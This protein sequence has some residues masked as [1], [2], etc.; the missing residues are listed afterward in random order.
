MRVLREAFDYEFSKLDPMAAHIDPPSVAVYETLL[1][2]GP[3]LKPYPYLGR[4]T[5]VS[6][7]GLEWI[8]ELRRGAVFH[9]GAP[10]DAQAVVASLEALRWHVSGAR[11]LWYWD[12]VD[13]VVAID[14]RHIKFRLHYP[15]S[16]L[17]ALLWGTHTAVFNVAL[18]QAD[19]DTFGIGIADGTGPYRMLS[20]SPERIVA[21]TVAGY[22]ARMMPE[23]RSST[24][25]IDRIEWV[26]IPDPRI[27]LE[28][29]R[30]GGIDCLHGVDYRDVVLLSDDLDLQVY[31]AGQASSMYWSLNW[32]RSD[33]GF[34][35]VHVRRAISLGIDRRALVEEVL[36]GHGVPTW[37][38]LPPGTQYYDASVD[39]EGVA[40]YDLACA[41]LDALGWHRGLDG[42][43]NRNGTRMAFDCVIQRD[44]VFVGVAEVLEAQLLRLG[45]E[46]RIIPVTPFAEFYG[47]CAAGPDSTISK[48]LWPD[49]VD[50]LIGFSSTST[51]PFPNW[52]R[53]SVPELDALFEAWLHADSEEELTSA[54][55]AVQHTFA[56][57]LPYLPLLAPADV[58]VWGSHVKGFDP[59][60]GI[61]YPFYQGVDVDPDP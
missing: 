44:A 11:Q 61:L 42:I 9:S 33:L 27:R 7:S 14:D 37:G 26:S 18:Q 46:I 1:A 22:P 43:R 16:R 21:E 56:R 48:W 60:P 52:S 40:N 24:R 2:K 13:T 58:W 54:A 34:D 20:F 28:V 15:Y 4:V 12:P 8:L 53:A 29:L 59:S 39:L 5:E 3:D 55:S 36:H 19:P 25:S 47:A 31:E 57:E 49:P 45:I 30:A 51:S 23:F 50:A 10:C 6:E 35:D 38:P 32:D 17:P 41:E